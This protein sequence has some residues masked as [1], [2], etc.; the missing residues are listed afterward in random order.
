MKLVISVRIFLLFILLILTV[1]CS[2]HNI[3]INSGGKEAYINAEVADTNEERING[4]MYRK[5]LCDNCG[6]LFVFDDSDYRS[7]WMKNTLIPLD[8][9]FIGENYVITD[10]K[11]AVPCLEEKCDTYSS[12][13][14]VKYVLEVNGGFVKE[15]NINVGDVVVIT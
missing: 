15:N 7:F 10:V 5:N 1:G 6:M 12:T 14:K 9:I 11:S 3:V 4:L 2:S 8:M 13:K